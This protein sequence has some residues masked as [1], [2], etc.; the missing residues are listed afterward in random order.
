MELESR[1]GASEYRWFRPR[2]PDEVFQRILARVRGPRR[3]AVDL[4]AGTGLVALRLASWFDEVVAVEP[5]AAMARQLERGDARIIE[6]HARAEDVELEEGCADLVSAGNSFHWMDGSVV[7]A[8]ARKWL[9]PGGV[10]AVFRYDPPHAA[11]GALDAVLSGEFAGRW[12]PHVHPRLFDPGYTR[13]T[14]ADS[15]FGPTLSASEI[16]N[17]LTLGIDELIGFC[18]S[19]SYAGGY[20]RTLPDPKRYWD[21]LREHIRAAAGAG[22]Y[23]LDFHVELLLATRA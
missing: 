18:R 19:T 16:P 7:V 8:R 15:A 20:A 5:D 11:E 13:R 21:E 1:F 4:G 14:L 22:P 6:L 23:R 10:L 12:R 2:W 9:R 17:V 3:R